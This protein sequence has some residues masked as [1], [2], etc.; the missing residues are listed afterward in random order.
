MTLVSTLLLYFESEPIVSIARDTEQLPCAGSSPLIQSLTAVVSLTFNMPLIRTAIQYICTPG[1]G[2]SFKN[3]TGLSSH[4]TQAPQCDRVFRKSIFDE[5]AAKAAAK[6]P[7]PVYPDEEPLNANDDAMLGVEETE[8]QSLNWG[9]PDQDDVYAAEP[10]LEDTH[11]ADPN[12]EDAQPGLGDQI[13]LGDDNQ[14][15][16][17]IQDRVDANPLLEEYRYNFPTAAGTVLHH[18]QSRFN[19][20]YKRQHEEGEGNPYYPFANE[21]DWELGAFM[22]E[23][24]MAMSEMDQFLKLSY[25]SNDLYIY[26]YIYII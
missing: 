5:Y 4:R 20:V 23:S 18:A 22:N 11:P 17:R 1:C 9:D 13:P 16:D 14:D 10:N 21:M 3:A 25:V 12:F 19:T 2:K 26:I 15:E 6:H 24:R 7:P 8:T